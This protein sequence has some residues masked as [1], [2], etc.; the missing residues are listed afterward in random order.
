Q[1]YLFSHKVTKIVKKFD[2]DIIHNQGSDALIQDVIT[3]HSCHR[4]WLQATKTVS[5][6]QFLKK[7][8][9]PL[10]YIILKNE[11]YN[12]SKGNYKK[13]IA[14]SENVKQEIILY[15]RLP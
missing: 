13:I 8:L 14:V 1:L 11:A 4:A 10:H 5:F 2:F 3:A 15:Y 12:Y 9:N 7:K 6:I